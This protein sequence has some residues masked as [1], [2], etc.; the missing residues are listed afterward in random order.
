MPQ[1]K[2]DDLKGKL[3][4]FWTDSSDYYRQARAMNL[5]M[6]AERRKMLD[7]IAPGA[8][9][10]DIGCGSGENGFH[11]SQ[12][13][14]YTGLEYSEAA[15]EMAREY[16]GP[17]ARFLQGDAEQLPFEDRSFDVVLSTHVIEHLANPA[18][19]IAEMIRVCKPGGLIL[20]LGPAWEM[21]YVYPP[22][23]Q[24]KAKSMGWR[25]QWTWQ[26]FLKLCRNEPTFDMIDDPDVLEGVYEVDNDTTYAVSVRRLV[27]YLQR[28][29]LEMAYVQRYQDIG[30]SWG[31]HGPQYWFWRMVTTLP[32]FRYANACLF[33]A[34]RK[35]A[36]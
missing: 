17:T 2:T 4:Q 7:L 35:P 15:L 5:E 6:T 24:K 33:I 30:P 26:R 11:I 10:L 22:S 12:F 1:P 31:H 19:V 8:K 13:A 32:V 14:D 3:L 16:A 36:S 29:G 18:L 20:I 21:P 25:L 28:S 27:N 34:A 9:V 23:C